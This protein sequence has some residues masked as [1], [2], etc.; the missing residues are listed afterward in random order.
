MKRWIVPLPGYTENH[1]WIESIMLPSFWLSTK[2]SW[3]TAHLFLNAVSTQV[4]EVWEGGKKVHCQLV[5]C[6]WCRTMLPLNLTQ[7][8]RP[9]PQW[10]ASPT[11]VMCVRTMSWSGDVLPGLASVSSPWERYVG[12]FVCLVVQVVCFFF[13][14]CFFPAWTLHAIV[15]YEMGF[16]CLYNWLGIFATPK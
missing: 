6:S 11:T 9:S 12:C 3:K 7:L 8:R 15:R 10:V 13:C 4:F 5:Y 16:F 2:Y 14:F 1:V